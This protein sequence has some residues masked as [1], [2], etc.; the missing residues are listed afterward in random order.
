MRDIPSIPL[1][2]VGV[3]AT[4]AFFRLAIDTIVATYD[5][6][7]KCFNRLL[8]YKDIKKAAKKSDTKSDRIRGEA[9]NRIETVLEDREST[10]FY[11]TFNV[12]GINVPEIN[13]SNGESI[14]G[15]QATSPAHKEIIEAISSDAALLGKSF[16]Y[17]QEMGTSLL[18]NESIESNTNCYNENRD[19]SLMQSI[20]RV[21]SVVHFLVISSMAILF[22]RAF[23]QDDLDTRLGVPAM[24]WT[25]LTSIG[26]LIT[27]YRDFDRKRFGVVQRQ[28]YFLSGFFVFA[29]GVG[30]VLGGGQIATVVVSNNSLE[31]QRYRTAP[32]FVDTVYL[33]SV[34]VYFGISFWEC[35]R[36]PFPKSSTSRQSRDDKAIISYRAVFCMLRPYLWPDPAACKKAKWHRFRVI[37]TWL[38]VS[39]SKLCNLIAPI[40]LGKASTSL[41]HLQYTKCIIFSI[42]YCVIMFSSGV[43]KEAQ[44]L[45]YLK[46]AQDAFVQ[47]SQTTFHHLHSLSLDWHLKKKL[48]EVT[49]AMERGINACD[50]LM[51][52]LFLR[53]VPTIAECFLVVIIFASYFD[54][55]V[56]SVTVFYFLFFYVVVTIVLTLWRKKFRKMV[57]KSDN[58]WHSVCTDSLMN[59]ETVKYFNA[60]KFE[61]ERFGEAVNRYQTGIVAVAQSQSLLDVVQSFILHACLASSLMLAAFG[62]KDRLKCCSFQGC[63]DFDVPCCTQVGREICPGMEIGDFVA[64]LAYVLQL[65]S[66]LNT[67]GSI[68]NSIVMAMVDLTNLLELL[69]LRPNV[70]D[71]HDA[72][73]LPIV[74]EKEPDVAVEFDN[75]RFNYPAQKASQGLKGLSFK[76]KRGTVTAIVGET[77]AGKTT[78]SRLLFRFYDV[79]SGAIKVNGL[80]IRAIRIESLREAFGVV[81]QNTELFNESIHCNIHY[82]KR[83]ATDDE[84]RDA[85]SAA[86]LDKLISTLP[87]GWDTVVG[88]RGLRLSGGEKQRAAIAR[89]LLKNPPFLIF[90]EAT[91]SLDTVT[92]N[93]VQEALDALRSDR[94]C[95]VIAHRLGTVRHA[96]NIIVLK[97]GQVAEEG[98]H[99]ELLSLKGE[100][101]KLWYTHQEQDLIGPSCTCP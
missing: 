55:F 78:V 41:A 44:G 33:I 79:L 24:I 56:L 49:R 66:P 9:R 3:G 61:M 53:L 80:D 12:D 96:D 25:A 2:S 26:C 16:D 70:V 89:C 85:I 71:S 60:E 14:S 32:S 83:E 36:C 15:F 101:A 28:L 5:E 10:I 97:A 69:V 29:G 95:L 62:I 42:A 90:D 6:N 43:L 65:F 84:I 64:V 86:Q 37:S 54:R 8:Q 52:F 57:S 58:H 27:N 30:L 76:M 74:N 68:Y 40:L 34:T 81:P 47:L 93:S 88:E 77:G 48:G 35:L 1:I 7:H 11:G 75:V 72:L 82:G 13:T 59:F 20:T 51:K 45:V 87:R 63:D 17:S 99:N 91:S 19:Q 23:Q 46:V 50:T 4:C 38:C 100:Y 94:T 21:S 22:V 98:T 39:G 92:E 67:L 18:Q 73:D 31:G